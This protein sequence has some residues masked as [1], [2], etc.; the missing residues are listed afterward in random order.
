MARPAKTQNADG[1]PVVKR[2][3][4]PKTLYLIFQ[5][6][7]D[8]ALVDAFKA[9]MA[10]VTMNSRALIKNLQGGSPAPFVSFQVEAEKRGS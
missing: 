3:I 9:S 4:G 2:E 1:T 5:P 8:P 10:V 6:G 7:T